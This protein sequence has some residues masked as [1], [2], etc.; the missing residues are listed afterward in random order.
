MVAS[1]RRRT[2]QTVHLI[3]SAEKP[4]E[5]DLLLTIDPSSTVRENGGGT[6]FVADQIS[7]RT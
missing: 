1:K 2:A 7:T 3:F 4:L 5:M 6:I